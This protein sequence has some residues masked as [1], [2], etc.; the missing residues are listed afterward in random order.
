MANYFK[1]SFKEFSK[2]SWPTLQQTVKLT[3]FVVGFSVIM[4]LVL[5][6]VDYVLNTGYQQVIDYSLQRQAS[7]GGDASTDSPSVSIDPNLQ[8]GEPITINA[9][10]SDGTDV[11]VQVTPEVVTP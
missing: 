9:E 8:N 6:A 11:D 7:N 4:A 3:G 5:G 2:V 10:G 1:E